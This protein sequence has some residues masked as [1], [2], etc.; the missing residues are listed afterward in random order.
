VLTADW[1]I[2]P[3]EL[4]LLLGG[5]ATCT[6]RPQGVIITGIYMLSNIYYLLLYYYYLL[7]LFIIIILKQKGVIQMNILADV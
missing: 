6:H 1:V 3:F 4:V 2:S 5:F 7:V